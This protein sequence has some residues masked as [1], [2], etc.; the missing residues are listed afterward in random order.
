MTPVVK[1]HHSQ[2]VLL[3]GAPLPQGAQWHI[4]IL[5]IVIHNNYNNK[6]IT[7]IN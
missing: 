3:L 5:F 6:I 7:P 2:I 4:I 1:F